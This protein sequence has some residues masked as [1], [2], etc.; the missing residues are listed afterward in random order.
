MSVTLEPGQVQL[1]VVH[2]SATPPS[3]D[4]DAETIRKWHVEGNGWSDIGYHGVIKRDGSFEQGRELHERGAHAK[5]WNAVSWGLCLVG[6]VQEQDRNKPEANYTPEQYK[7]LWAV[8][9]AWQSVAPTAHV[10]GHRDLDSDHQRLKA[11]PSFDVRAAYLEHC[12][13]KIR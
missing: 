6:G 12:L 10:C 13:A 5:G 3:A 11:C 7:T 9:N 1:L 8:L 4:I 2:C